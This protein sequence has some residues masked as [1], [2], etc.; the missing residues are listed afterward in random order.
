VKSWMPEVMSSIWRMVIWSPLA[1][2][3][4]NS[5]RWSSSEMRRLSTSCR[6]AVAVNVLVMLAMRT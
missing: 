3:G 4:T 1:T 5:L 6:I 2:E